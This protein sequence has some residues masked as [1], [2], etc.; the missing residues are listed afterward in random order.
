MPRRRSIYSLPKLKLKQ[1]T[2]FTV[3]TLISF[4]LA[5]LS[6]AAIFTQSTRIDF[7]RNLLFEN[8]GWAF[9]FTPLIFVL[10]GL[11]LLRLK[12][13]IAQ[14]NVLVGLITFVVGIIGLS[15]AVND[16]AGGWI[17]L[18]IWQEL[19]GLISPFGAGSVLFLVSTIG[20]IVALNTSIT[21]VFAMFG[22]VGSGVGSVASKV[23]LPEKKFMLCRVEE[24]G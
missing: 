17:G 6:L 20:L 12:W 9:I 24:E 23:R 10:I 7:W 18:I 1:K 11:V 3:A 21:E 4:A 15:A 2:V 8:I 13:K 22:R 19:S 14:A 16:S 5:V